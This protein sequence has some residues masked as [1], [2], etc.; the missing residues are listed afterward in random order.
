ML[1]SIANLTKDMNDTLLHSK[2]ITLALVLFLV[3][4]SCILSAQTMPINPICGCPYSATEL[5]FANEEELM[6]ETDTAASYLGG[7][8]A[9][10]R[11]ISYLLQHPAKNKNDSDHYSLICRFI[12]ERDG[13]IT[14]LEF[15]NKTEKEFEEEAAKII[16]AMPKWNPA[17]KD[18]HAVRSWHNLKFFFGK[19]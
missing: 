9:Y 13:S 11:Y 4:T 6:L 16:N 7:E 15:L 18:G 19:Y 10:N 12:V 2:Y 14:H 1:T 5:E 8:K 17:Q 3:T